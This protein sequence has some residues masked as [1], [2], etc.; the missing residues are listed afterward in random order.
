MPRK[1]DR[2]LQINSTFRKMFEVSFHIVFFLILRVKG[3][4]NDLLI[5]D[6]NFKRVTLR[7]LL[8]TER[9][10]VFRKKTFKTLSWKSESV[11]ISQTDDNIMTNMKNDKQSSKKHYTEN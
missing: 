10:I 6:Y 3:H 8:P 7:W 9:D 11:N 4:L 2:H 1:H 5:D